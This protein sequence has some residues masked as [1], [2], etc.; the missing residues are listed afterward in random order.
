MGNTTGVIGIE[1][2]E[3]RWLRML[4]SLLRH[5]DSSVPELAREA[6]LYLTAIAAEKALRLEPVT[7]VRS[8]VPKSTNSR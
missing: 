6:L 5:P 1:S 2:T 4:I 8:D 3:I 7:S